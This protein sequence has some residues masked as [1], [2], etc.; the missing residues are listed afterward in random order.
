MGKKKSTINAAVRG[1]KQEG[2]GKLFKGRSLEAGLVGIKGNQFSEGRLGCRGMED[3]KWLC[4]VL[5]T[6]L[7]APRRRPN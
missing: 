1:G 3:W 2:E 4:S 7:R 5:G 6:F